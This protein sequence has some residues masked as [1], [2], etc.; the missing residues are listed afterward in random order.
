MNRR[1]ALTAIPMRGLDGTLLDVRAPALEGFTANV[2]GP[3]LWPG[4][5]G[6]NEAVRI[7]NGMVS[8]RPAVVLQPVS[9]G[10]VRQAVQFARAN[11]IQL[12]VKGGG[13]NIAGTSLSDQGLTLDMS[14]L[15]SVEVDLQRRVAHVGAGCLLG[16][17]DRATQAHGLATVL[18]W[19]SETG[20]AGLTLGGGMGYLTRRFGWTVD[21]L[22]EVEIV[23]A[24]GTVRRASADHF[25]DLFWAIRG[26]GGN[27]GVVTRFTFR[28]HQIG[29]QV[30]GGIVLWDAEEAGDVLALYRQVSEVAPRE[31]TLAVTMRL[32]L[33]VP[34]IPE[35]WHGKPVIGIVAC[36]TGNLLQ[37]ATDLAPIRAFGKPIADIITEKRYVEQQSML[38]ASQP[39]GMHYYWKNEFLPDLSD[40]LLDAYRQHGAA[41]ASP[42][43]QAVI[44]QLGGALADYGP[45]DVPF[46]NRDA[47]YA[48]FAAGGWPPD[49]PDRERHHAWACSAWEAIRPHSTG[50]NYVNW[51]TADEDDTRVQEAYGDNLEI[52][53]KIKATYDPGNL[54]RVNRNIRPRR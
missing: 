17:V 7:W 45:S 18:G 51:Q 23:T 52:L 11:G 26:G 12:S 6:F 54:F 40:E 10:D 39:N 30:T 24:E 32:A 16:D 15:R 53:S 8:W 27:F 1:S 19:V 38:N 5:C 50:N 41:I 14:L 28:L 22:E 49:S 3:V 43:S 46:G 20:V 47:S 34:F 21:N 31:L 29:P 35:R 37:A 9:A 44:F 36:H 33:P 48:F 13:H 2:D 4:D 25:D 42:I